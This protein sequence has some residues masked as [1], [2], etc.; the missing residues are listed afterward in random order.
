MYEIG[1]NK[2]TNVLRYAFA[3]IAIVAVLLSSCALRGGLKSLVDLPVKTEQSAA[4]KTNRY[5]GSS[6]QAC[7]AFEMEE[8]KIAQPVSASTTDLLPLALFAAMALSYFGRVCGTPHEWR[9]DGRVEALTP[10]PIFL[11]YRKLLL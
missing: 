9:R 5:V 1:Q 4:K 8:T 2:S 11:R 6:Q 10:L 7:A 3:A